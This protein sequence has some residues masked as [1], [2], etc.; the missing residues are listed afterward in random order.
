[1][2]QTAPAH[3][4]T[5]AIKKRK[6]LR[7]DSSAARSLRE[8]AQVILLDIMEMK[9]LRPREQLG[10]AEMWEENHRSEPFGNQG[11]P[12]RDIRW[13]ERHGY[14]IDIEACKAR[15]VRITFCGRCLWKWRQL[16]LPFP[17]MAAERK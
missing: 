8:E 4:W 10:I 17:P 5:G 9:R 13:C 11:S 3:H 1:M 2:K 6:T 14:F 7:H 15:A 12:N 16:P